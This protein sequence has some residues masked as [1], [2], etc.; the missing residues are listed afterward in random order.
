M[1]SKHEFRFVVSGIELS[2]EQKEKISNAVGLA[3]AAALADIELESPHSIANFIPGE[4]L[5]R[6]LHV[7]EPGV[8]DEVQKV[9]GIRMEQG[10][11][12]R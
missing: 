8:S 6:W 4:W 11:L 9:I 10:G 2:E 3:G 7:L 1:S 12:E 5:G